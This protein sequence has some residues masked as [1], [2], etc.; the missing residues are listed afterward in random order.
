MTS[1]WKLSIEQKPQAF[2]VAEGIKPNFQ[3]RYLIEFDWRLAANWAIKAR[4]IHSK[5]EK[6]LK[7]LAIFDTNTLY[8]FYT[9][10][11]NIKD[12][13]IRGLRSSSTEKSGK[14]FSSMHPIPMP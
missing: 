14:A 7:I 12:E 9:I 3:I 10:I 1:N 8:K 13:T 6:L 4:Y 2:E 11:L 5:A